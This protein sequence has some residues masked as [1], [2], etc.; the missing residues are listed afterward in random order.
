MRQERQSLRARRPL[1]SQYQGWGTVFARTPKKAGVADLRIHDLRHTGATR[2][3][4]A[5]KN[6]R[7]VQEMRGHADVKTTMRYTHA[8]VDDV[9][10]AMTA[11]VIDEAARRSAHESRIKSRENP[12]QSTEDVDKKLKRKEK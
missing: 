10:E 11:R 9:A 4:R 8:L 5:S 2:T 12:E 7:A 6:L 3:L 1:P